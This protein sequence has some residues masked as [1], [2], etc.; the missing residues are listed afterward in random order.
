M[1]T[2]YQRHPTD[3]SCVI[4]HV[5]GVLATFSSSE[6]GTLEVTNQAYRDALE[7][8]SADNTHSFFG[9]LVD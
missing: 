1:I 6:N 2:K 5:S 9:K 8:A 7:T 3:D 4:L